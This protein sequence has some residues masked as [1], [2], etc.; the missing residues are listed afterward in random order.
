MC[1]FRGGESGAGNCVDFKLDKVTLAR[2]FLPGLGVSLALN[3][4]S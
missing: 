3:S 2:V 4:H 1:G